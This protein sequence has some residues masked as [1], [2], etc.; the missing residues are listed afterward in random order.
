[1]HAGGAHGR[2]GEAKTLW[3]ADRA[4]G[5]QEGPSSLAGV[6]SSID[7]FHI[8]LALRPRHGAIR[9]AAAG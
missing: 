5:L 2:P 1:M 7:W 4:V 8:G 6:A 3:H 9:S